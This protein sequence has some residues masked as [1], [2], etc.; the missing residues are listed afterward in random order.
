[1]RFYGRQSRSEDVMFTVGPEKISVAWKPSCEMWGETVLAH[2]ANLVDLARMSYLPRVASHPVHKRVSGRSPRSRLLALS[3]QHW[4]LGWPSLAL[5]FPKR[6]RRYESNFAGLETGRLSQNHGGVNSCPTQ[7]QRVIVELNL[8]KPTEV[9]LISKGSRGH[10]LLRSETIHRPGWNNADP[11]FSILIRRNGMRWVVQSGPRFQKENT[12]CVAS[13]GWLI[14]KVLAQCLRAARTLMDRASAQLRHRRR[15]S[16][17]F[18]CSRKP[19]TCWA[20]S[21]QRCGSAWPRCGESL[22]R[23]WGAAAWTD[24]RPWSCADR[25]S[26]HAWAC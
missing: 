13:L 26:H 2:W 8:E 9:Q 23:R 4:K 16:S 24:W 7:H 18:G 1:M 12:G 19:I 5:P 17:R 15:A 25:H 6:S 11:S 21:A 20:R 3:F 10:V 22:A 14:W